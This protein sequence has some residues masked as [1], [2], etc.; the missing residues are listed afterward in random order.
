MKIRKV[1][2]KMTSLIPIVEFNKRVVDEKTS[3]IKEHVISYVFNAPEP[4]R[5]V[6][7]WDEERVDYA[8]KKL[9]LS[10]EFTKEVEESEKIIIDKFDQLEDMAEKYK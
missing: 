6:F 8:I 5:E 3:N 2:R 1:V 10:P 7:E 4:F 9:I